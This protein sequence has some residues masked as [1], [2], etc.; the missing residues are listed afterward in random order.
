MILL[1]RMFA[2]LLTVGL[3]AAAGCKE[4]DE[5]AFD[6][7]PTPDNAC[8]E[9]A[10]VI[11]HNSFQ[12]CT[13]EDLED[14]FGIELTTSEGDCRHDVELM[15]ESTYAKQLDSL[16]A[17]RVTLNT[18]VLKQCLIDMIAPDDVCFPYEAIEPDAVERCDSVHNMLTG[19][20]AVGNGCIIDEDC[21]GEAYCAENQKCKD[22]LGAGQTCVSDLD[23]KE[24][25]HCAYN[26]AA[27]E[28]RCTKD[29]PMGGDC[30]DSG[31]CEEGL[32]CQQR[33]ESA[34][35]D[36]SYGN[37]RAPAANGAECK[38]SAGCASSNCLPGTCGD[39]SSCESDAHCTGTCSESETLCATAE[40]CGGSCQG[41]Y[42]ADYPCSGSS[43]CGSA[44]SLSGYSCIDGTDCGLVCVS[45]TGIPTTL[46][47]DTT[48]ECEGYY[49]VGYTCDAQTCDA[50]TCESTETCEGATQ[51]SG[52]VCAENYQVRDYCIE[53]RNWL[54]Y[55]EAFGPTL[56]N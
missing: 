56:G 13:G 31:D 7:N 39:G 43:E 40:D 35:I 9:I 52:R 47:C 28:M 20:V 54:G 48:T 33:A 17:G 4:E 44:C 16:A 23:C 49:G 46:S 6:S 22:L 8:A 51:C 32:F 29:I 3:V 45:D 26:E 38:Q 18:E 2:L 15:C 53:G 50:G 25:L 11:C 27:V 19:K 21:V 1:K 37:C 34:N 5:L 24:V 55:S 30:G 41:G 12:C 42:Y 14:Y 36:L 10:E